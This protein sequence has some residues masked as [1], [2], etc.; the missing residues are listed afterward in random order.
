M[1]DLFHIDLSKT[2][3]KDLFLNISMYWEAIKLLPDY[4]SAHVKD[5]SPG[6]ISP[7]AIVDSNVYG[8][9]TIVHPGTIIQGPTIIGAKNVVGPGA[10]IRSHVITGDRVK[11]GHSTEVNN[12]ILL[13]DVSIPHLAYVGHS[14]LGWKSHLA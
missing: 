4:V 2:K 1:L 11:L 6:S 12:S 9:G 10:F 3:H 14:I 5:I 8:H 13:D 7:K